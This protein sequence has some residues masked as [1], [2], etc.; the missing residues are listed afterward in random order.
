MQHLLDQAVIWMPLNMAQP[1][2]ARALESAADAGDI[3]KG[4]LT[5]LLG[6]SSHCIRP[7]ALERQHIWSTPAS[8]ALCL[9]FISAGQVSALYSRWLHMNT[10]W[11]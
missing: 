8:R 10:V 11:T 3:Q 1:T 4:C 9:C 2:P 5:R 7:H 6:T